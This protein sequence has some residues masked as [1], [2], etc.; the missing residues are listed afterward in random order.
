MQ[1]VFDFLGEFLKVKFRP[2]FFWGGERIWIW[3]AVKGQYLLAMLVGLYEKK[4]PVS[5]RKGYESTFSPAYLHTHRFFNSRTHRIPLL[6]DWLIYI[7]ITFCGKGWRLKE[8]WLIWGS[9][10]KGKFRAEVFLFDFCF[11]IP[12]DI[13]ERAK[14]PK[15]RKCPCACNSHVLHTSYLLSPVRIYWIRININVWGTK[16]KED[17]LYTLF[18]FL[19]VC[20]A[21]PPFY[22]LESN[23]FS[24]KSG[25]VRKRSRRKKGCPD[26]TSL[27]VCLTWVLWLSWKRDGRCR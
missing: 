24:G 26:L 13:W 21:A 5:M 9:I 11:Y 3:N 23:S 16:R 12:V 6:F 17:S 7:R 14:G 2:Y 4:I 15:S 19:Y 8:D 20:S 27:F 18:L 10:P 25:N 22:S 1:W